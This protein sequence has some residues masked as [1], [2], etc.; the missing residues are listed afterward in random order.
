MR[1][2]AAGLL[3]ALA[4]TTAGRGTDD[5]L[6]YTFRE[7]LVN[8]DDVARLEDL[9]GTTLLIEFWDRASMTCYGITVPT[10]LQ[11]QKK[12]GE[13]LQVLLVEVGGADATAM[14]R[15]ALEYRWLG[16][17]ALWTTENPLPS[18]ALTVPWGVV[19]SSWGEVLFA[20]NSLEQNAQLVA[21]IEN[22]LEARR[23]GPP[24][25]PRGLAR[26][27]AEFEKGRPARAL[28]LA[29]AARDDAELRG[30]AQVA[31]DVFGRRIETRLGRVS[32]LI[33]AGRLT[34]AEERLAALAR[35]LSGRDEFVSQLEQL[36]ARLDDEGLDAER[37]ADKALVKLE[38]KLFAEGLDDRLARS[39]EKLAEKH[40]GTR[41]AER[42]RRLARLAAED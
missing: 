18:A 14:Q 4:S 7:P 39:L 2:V 23:R 41:A 5:P 22:D 12:H 15:F 17:R 42:A 21:A 19:V 26:A 9:R 38:H 24:G 34:Q 31:L 27:W 40:T 3:L 35:S 8:G 25:T 32:T 16:G 36:R 30:A 10:C 1:F 28:A 11:L 20:G 37:E 13:D 29:E 33:E 6:S